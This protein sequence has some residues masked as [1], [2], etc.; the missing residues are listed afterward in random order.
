MWLVANFLGDKFFI[1]RHLKVTESP[2]DWDILMEIISINRILL[3]QQKR[4]KKS[5]ADKQKPTSKS[6]GLQRAKDNIEGNS[7]HLTG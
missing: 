3:P 2:T 5:Q 7:R 1:F 4:G 6:V